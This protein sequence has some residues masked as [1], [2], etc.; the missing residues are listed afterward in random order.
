MLGIG[1]GG[2]FILTCRIQGEAAGTPLQ[3]SVERLR[4]FEA[5][6]SLMETEGWIAGHVINQT[7]ACFVP[8]RPEGTA[9]Q[10]MIAAM[11]KA[12]LLYSALPPEGQRAVQIGV[13]TRREAPEQLNASYRESLRALY[14]RDSVSPIRHFGDVAE[15]PSAQD[16][17]SRVESQLADGVCRGDK[18]VCEKLLRKAFG[19]FAL[20]IAVDAI[21]DRVVAS[22]VNLRRLLVEV[23]PEERINE[24]LPPTLREQLAAAPN[25]LALERLYDGACERLI[26]C[27]RDQQKTRVASIVEQAE[28]VISRHY[29]ED[30]SLESTA[31]AIGVS[32]YYLSR[33]FKAERNVNFSAYL[34]E[35]RIRKACAYL[36]GSDLSVREIAERTGFSNPDYFGKVFKKQMGCTVSEYRAKRR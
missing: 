22:M 9:Y 12:N 34:T 31:E 15:G 18:A 16:P 2:G 36:D 23:I 26:A 33:L 19:G 11:E 7:L 13:G 24:C 25:A 28:R 32:Q 3:Q 29:M 8:Q 21:R 27:V 14:V 4:G 17:F 6:R 1:K 30:I 10:D 5:L 20:G 35:L